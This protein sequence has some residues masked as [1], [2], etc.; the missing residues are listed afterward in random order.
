[1][2]MKRGFLSKRNRVFCVA[3]LFLAGLVFMLDTQ[4]Q[5]LTEI[6]PFDTIQAQLCVNFANPR[7]GCGVSA[8]SFV[9]GAEIMG[10]FRW[11]TI[12]ATSG[13]Q[14][15]TT[16]VSTAQLNFNNGTGS[17]AN[18]LVTWNGSNASRSANN[19][20]SGAG[21]NFNAL[22]DR[23]TTVVNF[24][25]L[26]VTV[27]IRVYTDN[28]NYS[29]ANLV[30]P[31]GINSQQT[32]TTLFSAFG[33]GSGATG[34][35]NFNVVRRVTYLF[36][37]SDA[38][39]VR[40]VDVRLDCPTP[41][42]IINSFT[43]NPSVLTPPANTSIA[44]NINLNGNPLSGRITSPCATPGSYNLPAASGSNSFNVTSTPC[45]LTLKAIGT[46]DNATTTLTVTTTPPP[47]KVP[48]MNEW[49]VIILSLLLA[50]LGFWLLRKRRTS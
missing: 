8:E 14:D 19:F 29:D 46:C 48:S 7:V 44:W 36:P 38:L 42:P 26:G 35:A 13:N 50:G 17:S 23:F 3:I 16:N 25:D 21:F 5:A 27:R 15:D 11:L 2:E 45:V 6:D 28:T 34:A 4:A 24:C 40:I 39:D 30:L 37:G 32:F 49:G 43:A 9:A 41:A 20:N 22:G 31:S 47:G 18:L 10:G 12:D 1:M 33:I